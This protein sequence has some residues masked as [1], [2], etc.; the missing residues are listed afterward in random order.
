MQ[1]MKKNIGIFS[2][3]QGHQSIAETIKEKI[4]SQAGDRYRVDIFYTKQ[5]FE[6]FYESLYR[7]A[8]SVLKVPY[9]LSVKA[10]EKDA[11]LSKLIFNIFF[12]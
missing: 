3:K 8:P 5:I 9:D 6:T 10:I 7:L 4:E 11:E 12:Q 1:M 2:T